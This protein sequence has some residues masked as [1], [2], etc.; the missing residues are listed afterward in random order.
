MQTVV[1]NY[2]KKLQ[3]KQKLHVAKKQL[4]LKA[5]INQP[6]LKCRDV[7]TNKHT[8]KEKTHHESGGFSLL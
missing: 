3:K 2:R 1:R 6:V 7:A 5:V 8:T 4:V